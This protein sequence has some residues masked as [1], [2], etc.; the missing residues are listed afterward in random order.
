VRLADEE[1]QNEENLRA[2]LFVGDAVRG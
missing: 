1:P 2:R